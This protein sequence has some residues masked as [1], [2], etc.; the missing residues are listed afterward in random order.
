M[1]IEGGGTVELTH[2]LS[3]A[4]QG[5][6]DV[7]AIEEAVPTSVTID[8]LPACGYLY[9]DTVGQHEEEFAIFWSYD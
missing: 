9:R 4:I 6:V 2:Q 3:A 7:N 5:Y 1:I 8:S